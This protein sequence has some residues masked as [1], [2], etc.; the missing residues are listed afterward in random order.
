MIITAQKANTPYRLPRTFDKPTRISIQ[1]R[2]AF[3]LT[4]G[5]EQGEVANL[6][7]TAQDGLALTQL[8]TSPPWAEWV[9]GEI[10]YSASVDGAVFSVIIWTGTT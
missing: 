9:E 10:W 3:T 6:T 2:A 4:I 1:L 7:G 5:H 8:N